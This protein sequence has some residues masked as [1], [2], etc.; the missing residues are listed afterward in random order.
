MQV[1]PEYGARASGLCCD[2]S[3]WLTKAVWFQGTLAQQEV[4]RCGVCSG[5]AVYVLDGSFLHSS[6]VLWTIR[7]VSR[8]RLAARATEMSSPVSFFLGNFLLS[9]QIQTREPASSEKSVGTLL[10]VCPCRVGALKKQGQCCLRLQKDFV[11]EVIWGTALAS[12]GEDFVFQC[13]G[14][15]VRSLVEELRSH[16]P[17]GRKP[18]P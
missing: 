9:A 12:S 15:W 8:A 11:A 2:V 13:G 5:A 16:M 10:K 14:A 4:G 18:K 6:G 7:Q 1:H 17:C 3:H